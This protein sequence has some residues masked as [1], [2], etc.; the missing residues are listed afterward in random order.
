MSADQLELPIDVELRPTPAMRSGKSRVDQCSWCGTLV[1]VDTA[2]AA[3]GACPV[4]GCE[5]WW[6]QDRAPF[7]RSHWSGPFYHCPPDGEKARA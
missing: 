7:D 5:K 6:K 2:R 3:L 4:C 1:C